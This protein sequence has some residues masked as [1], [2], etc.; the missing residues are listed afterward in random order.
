[1]KDKFQHLPF[2][3]ILIFYLEIS[4]IISFFILYNINAFYSTL[5]F[6]DRPRKI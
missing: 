6:S 3:S 4:E 1:M 2:I 5:I